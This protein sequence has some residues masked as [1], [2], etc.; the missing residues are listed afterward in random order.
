MSFICVP[1]LGTELL[2]AFQILCPVHP[3][4]T[5]SLRQR[6]HS[7]IGD[8][9][10]SPKLSYVFCQELLSSLP[11][12]P[13]SSQATLAVP[14]AKF[15]RYRDALGTAANLE[16]AGAGSTARTCGTLWGSA[17]K[18]HCSSSWKLAKCCLCWP[19]RPGSRSPGSMPNR[20]AANS[21]KLCLTSI[22][23]ALWEGSPKS[24]QGYI[25]H[26]W[27]L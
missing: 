22:V 18:H 6:W 5:A 1:Q 17:G 16:G 13:S 2:T 24:P 26:R 3:A 19:A 8:M 11:S 14:S 25:L 12:A 20:T 21:T 4:S 7:N 15:S 23:Q 10:T 9:A 27:P